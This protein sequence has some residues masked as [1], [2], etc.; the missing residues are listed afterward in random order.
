MVKSWTA[1]LGNQ[2]ECRP[3]PMPRS[4]L[5]SRE[6]GASYVLYS[7]IWVSPCLHMHTTCVCIYLYTH[8]S[9]CIYVCTYMHRES[10]SSLTVSNSCA[11]AEVCM[12]HVFSNLEH[13]VRQVGLCTRPHLQGEFLKLYKHAE[14]LSTLT[15]WKW[16]IPEMR[17]DELTKHSGRTR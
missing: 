15:V 1:H 16:G 17:M 13:K 2:G 4:S 14:F 10:G 8:I 9:T 5:W 11:Q 6:R 7:P 3:D 12:Y